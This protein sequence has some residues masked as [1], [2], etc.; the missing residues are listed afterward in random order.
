[1]RFVVYG[2]PPAQLALPGKET[3]YAP[4]YLKTKAK[5]MCA[6][7]GGGIR[8]FTRVQPQDEEFVTLRVEGPGG[9]ASCFLFKHLM[10]P[11]F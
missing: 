1:M 9:P 4:P 2:M 10:Q 7:V 6:G 3:K 11:F 8:L 5:F